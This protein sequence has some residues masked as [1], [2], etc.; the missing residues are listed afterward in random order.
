MGGGTVDPPQPTNMQAPDNHKKI[1]GFLSTD[2]FAVD[3]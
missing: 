1:H 3:Y 2:G